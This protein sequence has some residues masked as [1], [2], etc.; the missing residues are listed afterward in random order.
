[1]LG[2]FLFTWFFFILPAI[3]FSLVSA[4]FVWDRPEFNL[5]ALILIFSVALLGWM[6]L[7]FSWVAFASKSWDLRM[8]L[9][10]E[11]YFQSLNL[12]SFGFEWRPTCGWYSYFPFEPYSSSLESLSY[13]WSSSSDFLV[14]SCSFLAF[15][16]FSRRRFSLLWE[17][18]EFFLSILSNKWSLSEFS[19]Y[20][21]SFLFPW[22]GFAH[23]Y[24]YYL[25]D[26]IDSLLWVFIFFVSGRA[27]WEK[28]EPFD[29]YWEEFFFTVFIEALLYRRL[30]LGFIFCRL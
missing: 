30:V 26:P 15:L 7:F 18:T 9:T 27:S 8:V 24:F 28:L 20:F 14:Y 19:T 4:S 22:W 13:P 23:S 5:E 21:A 17:L 10:G 1:M 11:D 3:T 25:I 16:I 6:V 2:T 29:F 12:L